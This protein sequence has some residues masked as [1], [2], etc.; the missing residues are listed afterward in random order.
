MDILCPTKANFPESP[1][2][3]IVIAPNRELLVL[4]L[5]RSESD[6]KAYMLIEDDKLT[7][8]IVTIGD[9]SVG[10]T[11]I[12]KKFVR[13]T[14]DP[15]EKNT[16][17]ALY[18]T[19]TDTID[20]RDIEVQIWDTA[21]QEQ[22]RSL[23][24]VYFRSAA[25]ALLVFDITNRLSFD[26]LDEWLISFRNASTAQ[27][28]LFLIGNKSDLEDSRKVQKFEGKDWADRHDCDYFETSARAG[29]GIR[30]LFREVAVRLTGNTV[31]ESEPKLQKANNAGGGS[32]GCC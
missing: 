12:V 6:Q 21:G 25:A 23:S 1:N 7:F 3:W 31:E 24:P 18:D 32:G 29:I 9:S 11:S 15:T 14:F 13:D 16:V 28:L 8:R 20:G 2:R 17:G 5:I 19:F 22:Y 10:K 4:S 27:A 30:E 26:N